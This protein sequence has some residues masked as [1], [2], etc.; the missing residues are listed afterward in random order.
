MARFITITVFE[1]SRKLSNSAIEKKL[2]TKQIFHR[3]DCEPKI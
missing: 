2:N 3:S 1:I